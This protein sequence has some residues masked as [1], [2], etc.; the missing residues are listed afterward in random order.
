[1][2]QSFRERFFG[3]VLRDSF[4]YVPARNHEHPYPERLKARGR[5]GRWRLA[6]QGTI[7]DLGRRSARRAM[8][9]RWTPWVDQ[10]ARELAAT[11]ERLEDLEAAYE[12]L[13]DE[14]SRELFVRLIEWRILGPRRVELPVGPDRYREGLERVHREH[15]REAGTRRGND[16]YFPQL[17]RYAVTVGSHELAVET[18]E[19]C[20]HDVFLLEEYAYRRGHQ[21]VAAE[22]D[23][24]VLDGGGGYGETALYFSSLV[25]PNG[26]VVVVEMDPRNRAS[27][28]RN[29][30]QNPE[31]G[32]R[33]RIL[34]AALWDTS[35]ESLTYIAS[36]KMSR[37]GV[38]E[39]AEGGTLETTTIDELAEG[40]GLERIN[41]LKLDIEG[42]ELRAL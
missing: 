18:D 7:A 42:A 9:S 15:L 26:E 17:N 37:L 20:M 36:G 5:L 38:P 23:D 27:I 11:A 35:G 2:P 16:P 14:P 32:A 41:L 33:V 34:D 8:A 21:E 13:S 6:A 24:L 10:A 40:A 30:E 39:A 4:G 31:L 3:D 1:M 22:P 29:L 12:T 19:T 25:A 28:E